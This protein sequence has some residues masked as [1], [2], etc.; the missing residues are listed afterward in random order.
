MSCFEVLSPAGNAEMLT[1]ACRAGADAVYLG[2]KEFSARR[3]AENFDDSA[4][5]EAVK[6]CHIR[7]VKVYL[8]LNIQIKDSE[9]SSAVDL[10]R[11]AYNYGIDG[12]IIADLGLAAVLRESIPALHLHASTQMTVHT[13]AALKILKNAGFT[14]V[15][16]AREM[17]REEL[18]ELCKRAK[19]L[20]IEV[21]VFVHGAL[22][23]SVSGQCLLSAFLGSRSGNRGLCAGPCRLP[24]EAKGGTGYDLSLKD[25]SLLP[26][27]KELC[28]MGVT[29]F[30]IEGRMKRPEYVAAATA[31]CRFAVDNGYVTTEDFDTLKNVFSR[32]GFTDGYYVNRLGRDMFGIRTKE[33]VT[34]ADKAFPKIHELIRAERK[35]VKIRAEITVRK[36]MPIA[37]TL[38]DGKNRVTVKGKI[39][40][41]AQNRPITGECLKA[42][43]DKFG[44]TPYILY[45]FSAEC[46]EGLFVSAAE[47]NA[48]RR[49]AA[50]LLDRKRGEVRREESSVVYSLPKPSD[51]RTNPPKFYARFEDIAQIPKC[52]SGIDAVIFP[53]EKD[54]NIDIG[55]VELIADI[56]R[57]II[58]EDFIR[59][60]LSV[61]KEKGFKT[62][63][64]GNLSAVQIAIEEG[65]RIIAGTGLNVL[66]TESAATVSKL[67]AERVILSN[68]ITLQGAARLNS[69]VPRGIVAYGNIPLMLFRNCPL[70][71]GRRCADCDKKGSITDR[72]NTEFPVR[73]R[74]GFSELLNSVPVWLADRREDLKAV[75]FAVLYFTNESPERVRNVIK[76]YKNGL[77]ADTEYTRGL[78]YRGTI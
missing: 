9:L 53:L 31:A 48:L 57:G 21:E 63:V 28:D 69:P 16:A 72:K 75:D 12:V 60:R 77:S 54:F 46:G 17:S 55:R 14:R 71:N 6:Y 76:A 8:T 29:S 45:K 66:N 18:K 4:I 58:S 64:C 27:I 52:L 24:F 65:F 32:S 36:D 15:V 51:K 47:L 62:A 78:F 74:R 33:D 11:R 61:F 3:N 40:K 10:A 56:P 37:L 35:T 20:D 19:E 43:L 70:K 7:G 73:C 22:C 41:A 42:G 49:E 26:Y 13:P 59:Q 67:G 23:M 25:L 1:A 2:A 30:K 44:S 39:P 5:K 50:E 38:D 34:A 68:E